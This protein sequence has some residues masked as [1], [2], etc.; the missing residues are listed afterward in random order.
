M[1]NNYIFSPRR[2]ESSL[3]WLKSKTEMNFAVFLQNGC[4]RYIVHYNKTKT[5]LD[6]VFEQELHTILFQFSLKL[7]E[8]KD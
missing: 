7:F 5:E 8:Q 2:K 6:G 4:N 3:L 1:R